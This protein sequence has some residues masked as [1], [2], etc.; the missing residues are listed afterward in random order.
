V[1]NPTSFHDRHCE[2]SPGAR[3]YHPLKTIEAEAALRAALGR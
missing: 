3:I 2:P 1:L